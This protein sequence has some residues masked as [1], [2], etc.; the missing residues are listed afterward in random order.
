M[1]RKRV[2]LLALFS[3]VAL[4]VAPAGGAGEPVRVDSFGIWTLTRLGYGDVVVPAD[5]PRSS[6]SVPFT[7]PQGARQGP[8]NWYLIHHHFRLTF[9]SASGEGFVLVTAATNG[10]AASS[11]EFTTRRDDGRLRVDWTGVNLI[12]GP[13]KGIDVGPQVDLRE[14]NFLQ[15]AGVRGGLNSLDFQV[16]QFGDSRVE[17][18]EV[19]RDSGI[20]YSRVG[21]ALLRLELQDRRS[22][23]SVGD[24]VRV[25]YQLV[26]VKGRAIRNV[27]I[28]ATADDRAMQ[29]IGRTEVTT[30]ISTRPVRGSFRFR[31]NKTGA[32]QVSVVA[33]TGSGRLIDSTIVRVRSRATAHRHG[34]AGVGAL[35]L[36]AGAGS[37]L[38]VRSTRRRRLLRGG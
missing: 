37:F 10:R 8:R 14:V 16:E 13:T 24:L 6:V 38:L 26:K 4:G 2:A 20:E 31:P 23:V 11:I 15:Y 22:P 28:S 5:A 3:S 9:D 32:F 21:P 25:R 1:N 19:S 34:A 12:E 18:L 36:T 7:L 30:A 33:R 17:R 29:P 35:L 27:R